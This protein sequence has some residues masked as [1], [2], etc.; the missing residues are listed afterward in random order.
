MEPTKLAQVFALLAN[1]LDGNENGVVLM[2]G[3]GYLISHNSFESVL[4]FV[5]KTNEKINARSANLILSVD[6]QALEPRSY[7]LIEGEMGQV[8]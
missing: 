4:R 1:F 6:P 7:S 8:I 2:E 5:Q 3:I